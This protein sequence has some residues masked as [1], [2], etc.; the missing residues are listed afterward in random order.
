MSDPWH[1]RWG[2]G[3]LSIPVFTVFKEVCRGPKRSSLGKMREVTAT[4]RWISLE[5][6]E[7][8]WVE[9]SF[10]LICKNTDDTCTGMK[11]KYACPTK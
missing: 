9:V 3:N 8:D 4:H 6:D 5:P 7:V 2:S 10:N 1:K 11:F